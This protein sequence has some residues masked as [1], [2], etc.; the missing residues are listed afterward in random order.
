LMN[1][2]IDMKTKKKLTEEQ[3]NNR[4]LLKSIMIKA[5]FYPIDLEWWHFNVDEKNNI[6][7]KYKIIE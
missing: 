1:I 2:L 4:L 7:K 3:K 6:R 5:G